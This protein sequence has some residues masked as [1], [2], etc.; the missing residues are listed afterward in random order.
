[1]FRRTPKRHVVVEKIIDLRA[2][3][4]SRGGCD[5]RMGVKQLHEQDKG[6]VMPQ[7]ADG[8]DERE[9]GELSNQQLTSLPLV[10]AVC[11][12]SYEAPQ[13]PDETQL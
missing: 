1:M 8:P 9:C 11:P 7:G 2:D 12:V 13:Q 3:E 6:R 5:H 4:K 10:I